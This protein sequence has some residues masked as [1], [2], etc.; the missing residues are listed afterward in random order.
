[1]TVFIVE[2][3]NTL[4]DTTDYVYLFSTRQKAEEFVARNPMTNNGSHFG[5]I[6][7]DQ[8]DRRA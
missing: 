8:I 3:I 7:Y 4:T 6:Y 5:V 1:M 2:L